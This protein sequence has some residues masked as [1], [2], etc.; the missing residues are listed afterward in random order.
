MSLKGK[1]TKPKHI[2]VI[3]NNIFNLTKNE[4]KVAT[5]N[6]IDIIFHNHKSPE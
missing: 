4:K 6:A 2:L 3:F 1:N 5:Y